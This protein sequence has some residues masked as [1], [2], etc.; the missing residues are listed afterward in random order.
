[1][2]ADRY[3]CRTRVLEVAR[4]FEQMTPASLD[5][6]SRW[7]STGAVFKDPFNEVSGISRIRSVFEH[8]YVKLDQ[9][10]FVVR[11][12]IAEGAQ[13]FLVWDFHFS[14]KNDHVQQVVRGSSH[15]QF[16]T[17]GLICL[18]RDYWDAAEELYEK[19]PVIGKLMLWLKKR[20][21]S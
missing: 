12:H 3:C 10:R 17:N 8:M 2:T 21:V 20:A 19:L 11:E 6:L 7:Y 4:F 14:F 1:M 16:D 13:A 18:H 9:P 15:L 5:H